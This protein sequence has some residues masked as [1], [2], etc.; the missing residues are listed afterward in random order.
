MGSGVILAETNVWLALSLSGDVFHSSA[1][2]WFKQQSVPGSVLFCRSTQQ[3]LLRLLTT[4]AV[5]RPYGIPRMTNAAA[6]KL[7]AALIADERIAWA[8]EPSA[9]AVEARWHALAARETAS[10]KLWMDAYL[11]AFALAGG[12][13]L[14]TTDKAFKQFEGLD[15]IVLSS[16]VN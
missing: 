1:R 16:A 10:A 5:M 8:A 11:A 6:W 7:Y 2:D 12:H 3:S 4:E 15:A 9:A 14:A 13:Q